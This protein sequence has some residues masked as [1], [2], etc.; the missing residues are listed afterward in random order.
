VTREEIETISAEMGVCITGFAPESG[1][2]APDWARTVIILGTPMLLPILDTCPSI[3]GL[4]HEKTLGRL[5][6]KAAN[7]L[8]ASLDS[9]GHRAEAAKMSIRDTALAGQ[10]A[11]LGAIGASGRLLTEEYG[12]RVM[13]TAVSASLDFSSVTPRIFEKHC[14]KCGYC[15]RIC[16]VSASEAGGEECLNYNSTLA[17]DFK[18]PCLAC[19][20][21]CPVGNDR[22][23]YRSGNFEK[24]FNERKDQS[25]DPE[26]LEYKGWTH[27]R[28][29]GS[30]PHKKRD[31]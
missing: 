31:S 17:R 3:W 16:P 10:L 24:Y 30:Y 29:Y 23:L 21:V 11:G 13:W 25:G 15:R 9:N 27:V 28:S 14:E 20:K 18:N 5:L 7:R 6:A 2:T 8:A 1:Y 22:L 26:A 4:E 19:M 12:P